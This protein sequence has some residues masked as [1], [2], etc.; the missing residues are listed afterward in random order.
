MSKLVINKLTKGN[1][2]RSNW[3]YS[4]KLPDTSGKFVNILES[5]STRI[6]NTTHCAMRNSKHEIIKS[7]QATCLETQ[8]NNQSSLLLSLYSFIAVLWD[9]A[10]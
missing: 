2:H 3:E 10:L 4:E 7:Q 5:Y 6:Y 8:Q 9:S 1:K